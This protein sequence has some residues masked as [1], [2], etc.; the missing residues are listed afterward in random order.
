M[1]QE[2]KTFKPSVNFNG[3]GRGQEYGIRGKRGYGVDEQRIG[4]ISGHKL[5]GN[6]SLRAL[7]SNFLVEAWIEMDSGKL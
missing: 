4:D 6:S 1:V 7:D 3:E 5:R 2:S